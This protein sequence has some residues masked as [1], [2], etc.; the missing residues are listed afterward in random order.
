MAEN[1][2]K[3]FGENLA[4]E[5]DAE[6][7]AKI[8]DDDTFNSDNVKKYFSPGMYASSDVMNTTLR[9]MSFVVSA[10]CE[11]IKDKTIGNTKIDDITT[12]KT[13]EELKENY[14]KLVKYFKYFLLG[15]YDLHPLQLSDSLFQY[16]DG[17]TYQ[18]HNGV[19]IQL[20]RSFSNGKLKLTHKGYPQNYDTDSGN[21]KEKFDSIDSKYDSLIVSL[22]SLNQITNGKQ[23]KIQYIVFDDFPE[24]F[25]TSGPGIYIATFIAGSGPYYTGTLYV[26]N[27]NVYGSASN[28]VIYAPVGSTSVNLTY[29]YYSDGGFGAIKVTSSTGQVYKFL[30][31]AKISYNS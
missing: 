24:Y 15:D 10:L 8:Y 16:S 23:N 25:V 29:C 31:Y 21:I 27:H 5:R 6:T 30:S 19:T 4:T 22:S 12:G 17:T 20:E 28:N 11:A 3:V 18:E 14:E 9:Q 7:N 2:I 13:E 26:T 1:K